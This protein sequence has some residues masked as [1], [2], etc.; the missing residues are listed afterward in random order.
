MDILLTDEQRK[1]ITAH[2]DSIYAIIGY[3][4]GKT[5][6]YEAKRDELK[7]LDFE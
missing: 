3:A 2:L 7:I 6:S 4:E 1:A 5:Q